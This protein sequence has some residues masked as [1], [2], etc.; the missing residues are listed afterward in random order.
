MLTFARHVPGALTFTRHIL[1]FLRSGVL[2]GRSHVGQTGRYPLH[3]GINDWIPPSSSYG[4]PLNETTIADHFQ[5]AGY[6]THAIGKT[7]PCAMICAPADAQR[8][9]PCSTQQQL[10]SLRFLCFRLLTIGLYACVGKWHA[11]F[12]TDE[13]TPTFRGFESARHTRSSLIAAAS[14]KRASGSTCRAQSLALFLICQASMASTLV[15]K[16]SEHHGDLAISVSNCSD[17][18][19]LSVSALC[20]FTHN[21]GGYDFHRD[22]KPNCHQSNCSQVAWQDKGKYS[23]IAFAEEAVKVVETHPTASPLFLCE[24]KDWTG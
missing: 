10:A 4:M 11:G 8:A 24:C 13:F 16:T 21:A 14:R 5:T 6:K 12:Y 9:L 17:T 7:T 20:S 3:H 1:T 23:T 22:P 15:A 19:F 2:T 18:S